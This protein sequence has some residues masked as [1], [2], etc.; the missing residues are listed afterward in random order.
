[1]NT[2][3]M[4]PGEFTRNTEFSLPTER[5]RRAITGAAGNERTHFVNASRVA[6]ALLGQSLG[7]NMFMLGYAYQIGALPLSAAAIERALELNGEAVP[8]N[9]AA[10]R[11]GR[12][13][14]LD[15]AAVEKLAAPV[16]PDPALGLS[17]SFDE[18]V[19][20][21]V[22]FLTEYQNASYA[23]RYRAWVDKAR[24]AE[25]ARAR[26]KCGLA[27]AV[28]RY[29][30]KLMAYKDEYEVARLYTDGAFAAQVKNTFDGDNLRLVVHLSPPLLSP[31]DKEGH[32][33]KM[34]FGPWMFRAFKV[35]AGLKGLRGTMFDIFGHTAERKTER[36]LIADYEAML[37]EVL[38]KLTPEN[39]H[40]A[41]GLAAIPEKIRGF[42]HIKMRHLAAAKADEAALLEQFRAGPAPL[43]KAAE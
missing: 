43:L 10:F 5:L 27:E 42:G 7:A 32:P 11:W 16:T 15:L 31:T 19:A 22:A 30:F 35:L 38:G 14:A 23:A 33:R 3:E 39:H 4:L 8:M 28:A 6:T 37:G 12:R 21:R 40:V 41:V 36:R 2:A 9:V 13:A 18:M 20:R 1:I 24:G 17:Q 25:S 26:D 34:T 29:L